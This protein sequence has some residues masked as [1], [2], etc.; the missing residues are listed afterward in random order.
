MATA[1]AQSTGSEACAT[2]TTVGKRAN[3]S[4]IERQR[5]YLWLRRSS[6]EVVL[7]PGGLLKLSKLLIGEEAGQRISTERRDRGER[8][9]LDGRAR[10]GI[11]DEEPQEM[12]ATIRF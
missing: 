6:V 2:T 9:G 4:R 8:G 7:S 12:E 1:L 3:C 10:Q 11:K 5:A